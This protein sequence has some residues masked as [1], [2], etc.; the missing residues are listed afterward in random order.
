MPT[1]RFATLTQHVLPQTPALHKEK[2]SK[3]EANATRSPLDLI[4]P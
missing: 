2:K 3:W 4:P 1:L